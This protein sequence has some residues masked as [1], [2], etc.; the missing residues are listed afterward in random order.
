[1]SCKRLLFKLHCQCSLFPNDPF[2]RFKQIELFPLAL[3][4]DTPLGCYGL[5]TNGQNVVSPTFQGVPGFIV[6]TVDK[7][8]LYCLSEGDLFVVAEQRELNVLYG[9]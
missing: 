8:K 1:M 2:I 7:V 3:S 4:D 9:T 6:E 5:S